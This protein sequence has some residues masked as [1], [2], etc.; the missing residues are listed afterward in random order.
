MARSDIILSLVK[1]ANRGDMVSF[2]RAVESLVA[3]ERS[4]NHNILA[5]Q[6]L[7]TLNQKTNILRE[8]NGNGKNA[9]DLLFQVMPE[10]SLDDLILKEEVSLLCREL[11]E[12]QHRADLLRSHAIE[13]RHRILLVGSPGNGKT[14]IAEAIAFQLM[15]PLFVIRYDNLIGSFLGETAVRLQKVFDY[16]KSHKCVLF[17]DEFDTIGKERGDTKETGEIKRVVSS[18]LLQMDRLPSYV[19]VITASNHPELL[20]RAVWRRFQV[21]LS[22]ESPTRAQIEKFLQMYWVKSETEYSGANKKLADKLYGFSFGEIEDFCKDVVRRT[23]L[24]FGKKNLKAIISAKLKQLE[25]GKAV[26]SKVTKRHA[27]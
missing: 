1:S 18:L 19:V 13:P 7:D 6:L 26:Q 9:V 21:K 20:D 4:K 14:S 11:V 16:A 8:T 2:R 25:R 22:L 27:R 10:R 17:F 23:I 15:Y 12:E 5:Q 3:E 24:S